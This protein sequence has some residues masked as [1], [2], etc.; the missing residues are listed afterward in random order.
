MEDV[1][2]Q[3]TDGVGAEGATTMNAPIPNLS[4]NSGIRMPYAPPV[5]FCLVPVPRHEG[6]PS[7]IVRSIQGYG[8]QGLLIF[9]P[10]VFLLCTGHALNSKSSS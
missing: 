7:G 3:A 4:V 6:R 1:P 2:M 8:V 5:E 9:M 10:L